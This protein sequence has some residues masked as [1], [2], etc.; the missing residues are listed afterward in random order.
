MLAKYNLNAAYKLRALRIT[1]NGRV[2]GTLQISDDCDAA[3]D[4]S[5]NAFNAVSYPRI[6]VSGT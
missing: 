5:R 2:D 1:S 3:R 6:E 4:G